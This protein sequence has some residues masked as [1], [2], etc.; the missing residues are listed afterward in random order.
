[1]MG[2]LQACTYQSYR[3]GDTRYFSVSWF[4]NN[5]LK[6]LNVDSKTKETETGLKIQSQDNEVNSKAIEA[7]FEGAMKGAIKGVK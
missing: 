3:R 2:L 6:G 5:G 4:N 1:M 7:L